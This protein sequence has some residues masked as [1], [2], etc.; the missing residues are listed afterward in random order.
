MKDLRDYVDE[1]GYIGHLEKRGGVVTDVLEFGDGTQRLGTYWIVNYFSNP[2]QVYADAEKMGE[3][4]LRVYKYETGE[5]VRHWDSSKWPGQPGIMSRDNA[6]PLMVSMGFY[7]DAS[8]TVKDLLGV[9][10]DSLLSRFGFFWNTKHIG[11]EEKAIKIPDVAGPSTWAALIRATSAWYLYPLLWILDL[12]LILG[13]LTRI[14]KSWYDPDDVGDDLNYQ[15][16]HTQA[17]LKWPTVWS[18]SA[19]LFYSGF[20]FAAGRD[21]E[22]RLDIYPP[23]SPWVW[24]YRHEECPPLDEVFK[25]V[26]GRIF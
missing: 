1:Y 3:Q 11:G 25:P 4:Y 10:S 26:V 2:G 18:W 20:R 21:K 14:V 17:Y 19:R 16:L 13:A 5:F 12:K 9:F 23:F 22:N 24:Y 8:S 6:I 15:I 7:R